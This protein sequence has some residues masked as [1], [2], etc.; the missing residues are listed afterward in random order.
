[1]KDETAKENVI[2]KIRES[3]KEKIRKAIKV[4]GKK[5]F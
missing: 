4:K 2:Q 5:R 1:M 3:N